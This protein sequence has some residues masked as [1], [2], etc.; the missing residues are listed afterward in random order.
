MLI[1]QLNKYYHLYLNDI[2]MDLL[3][4]WIKN[5]NIEFLKKALKDNIFTN[6]MLDNE[7]FIDTVLDLLKFGSKVDLLLNV[8]GYMQF[9][10][11]TQQQLKAFVE[12]AYNII[13]EKFET[14]IIS[15]ASN[16]V[17]SIWLIWECLTKIGL[18]TNFL[19]KDWD[20]LILKL[21]QLAKKVVDGLEIEYFS[22]VFF[23]TDFKDRTLMR[24]IAQRQYDILFNGERIDLLLHEIW[25]G[26]G[27]NEW[28]GDLIDFSVLEYLFS[29]PIKAIKGQELNVK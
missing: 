21:L 24:I 9:S 17:L 18:Y 8:L 4:F 25:Q 16:P 28:N 19:K 11:W 20:N 7:K 3:I 15:L 27:A 10:S 14:N 23:D 29:S 1:L 22:R 12:V 26:D 6:V 13:H 5:T 2:N